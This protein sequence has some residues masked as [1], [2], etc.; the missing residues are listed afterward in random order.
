MKVHGN[1]NNLTGNNF[2]HQL[3]QLT[4]YKN[5]TVLT[6]YKVYKLNKQI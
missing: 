4:G 5:N 1:N 6:K 2:K 3:A